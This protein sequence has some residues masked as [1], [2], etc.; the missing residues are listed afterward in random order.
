M[1]GNHDFYFS[2]FDEVEQKLRKLVKKSKNLNWLTKSGIIALN[3]STALIGV[4][5]WGDAR[6]GNLNLSEGASRDVMS[7][8]DYKGIS[9]EA[10]KELLISKGDKYAEILRPVLLKAVKIFKMSFSNARS[11]VCRSLFW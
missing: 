1:L 4:E 10:I 8:A 11:A 9:R 5:G 3:D 6:H 7:I 2:S